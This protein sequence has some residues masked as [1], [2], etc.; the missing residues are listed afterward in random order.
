MGYVN[1]KT[2]EKL[3]KVYDF[4]APHG[5]DIKIEDD[6]NFRMYVQQDDDKYYLY[7]Y[8]A[9]GYAQDYLMDPWF[10]VEITFSPDRERITLAKPI[11][12]LSQTFLGELHIDEFDNMEGFG[13]IKEHEDGIMNENFDS[14]LDTITNIRPYLTSPKEVIRFKED[15]LY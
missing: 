14:F 8:S 1:E 9:E 15:N 2:L 10:K 4:L 3:N 5:G 13:G 12:Y 7:M 6:W 11:E